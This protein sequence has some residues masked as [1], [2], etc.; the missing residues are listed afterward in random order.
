MTALR[1]LYVSSEDVSRGDGP[2]VNEREFIRTLYGLLGDS[3]HFVIPRPAQPVA[4]LPEQAC[5]FYKSHRRHRPLHYAGHLISQ[6]RTVSRYLSSHDVDLLVLR[7]DVLPIALRYLVR[8]HE[9]PYAIKT[10]SQGTLIVLEERSLLHRVLLSRLNTRLT[11]ELV[12][13]AIV[14]DVCSQPMIKYFSDK[15]QVDAGKLL[16]VDNAVDT[17]RFSP[18]LTQEAR[19]KAN[20]SMFDS[21]VGYIGSRPSERGARHLVELAPRLLAKHSGLGI[22]IVGD[23]PGLRALKYRAGELGVS[24]RCVFTGYVPFDEIPVYC[25]SMDV[26]VSISY[27]EDRFAAA[28][29]KVRQY[30]ACGRPVVASAGSNEFLREHDIGSVVDAFD[31]DEIEQALNHWL[32]LSALSGDRLRGRVRSFACS[33]L[34]YEA[35]V[36]RRLEVWSK[37]IH[38]NSL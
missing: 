3:A 22:V 29:L 2:G 15:L 27:R 35:A 4:D 37:L 16:W 19:E 21:V 28:E 20:L 11:R 33:N 12:A 26:G 30:L 10:L 1:I 31:L 17:S 36:T 8:N 38:K 24:D 14:T 5:T 32:A 6:A 7:T 25:N 13:D 34:S 18:T 9:I 23:G